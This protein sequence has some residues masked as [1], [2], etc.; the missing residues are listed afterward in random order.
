MNFEIGDTV[1]FKRPFNLLELYKNRSV[2]FIHETRSKTS[3]VRLFSSH[4]NFSY[5]GEVFVPNEFIYHK[6]ALLTERI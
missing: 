4:L 3:T 6:K 5:A 2:L 1:K